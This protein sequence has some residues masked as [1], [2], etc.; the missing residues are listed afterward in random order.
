MRTLLSKLFRS[1]KTSLTADN[2][3]EKIESYAQ[4]L[5]KADLQITDDPQWKKLSGSTVYVIRRL[6]NM[7]VL[8]REI[9]CLAGAIVGI[10]E[11]KDNPQI[12]NDTITL[13]IDKYRK[14]KDPFITG[15]IL[16]NASSYHE[17]I[18]RR[19]NFYLDELVLYFE[20]KNPMASRILFYQYHPL[21]LSEEVHVDMQEP[22]KS[23]GL[24]TDAYLEM[25]FKRI[26]LP[27]LI[28]QLPNGIRRN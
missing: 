8:E 5:L 11:L 9:L 1:N 15:G 4:Q 2:V 21:S 22:S 16:K 28:D 17:F 10:K 20:M 27:V 12:I 14:L 3:F 7:Y 19:M 18:I 13:L 26:T 24:I 6:E 23:E 25:A